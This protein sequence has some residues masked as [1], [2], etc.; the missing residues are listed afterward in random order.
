MR[1]DERMN[2]ICIIPA[3]GGSKRIPG[4]N[5]KDFL[6]KP[7][8]AYSIQA[9]KDSGLFSE[10]MVSTDCEDIANISLQYGAAVPFMRSDD[11][12]DDFATTADVLE[13]VLLEYQERGRVFQQ[14]CCLYPAAPLV[15]SI[16]LIES[17]GF[18]STK[19]FDSLFPV[20]EYS[21]G[22]M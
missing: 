2:N 11:N 16:K 9:A 15:T 6:G 7:I 4:K 14:A 8:I 18:L 22:S 19:K 21:I 5:I 13:E 12:S 20:V 1:I 10:V 17:Y 3:R